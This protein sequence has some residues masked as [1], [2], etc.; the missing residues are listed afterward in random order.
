M[1]GFFEVGEQLSMRSK[2]K[3]RLADR[4]GLK[5]RS[6]KFCTAWDQ[7]KDHKFRLAK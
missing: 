5:K 3:A 1:S 6:T 7:L 2:R 4:L